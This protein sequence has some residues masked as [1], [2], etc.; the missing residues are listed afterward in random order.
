MTTDHTN[1]LARLHA[2][3]TQ[4][5]PKS[6][7]LIGEIYAQNA[8]FKDPFNEVRGIAAIEHIFA[9]MFVQVDRPRFEIRQTVL[10][11]GNA[12]LVWDFCFHMRRWNKAEQR[13][14]GSSHI[15][16]DSSGKVAHHRDY[17]DAAE[18]LYEK[19]PVL[20]GLMRG[21]KRAAQK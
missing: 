18:E 9:H 17:W 12:F 20:A 15:T 13:I 16:F 21:L 3:F 8:Y 7:A 1:D 11:G 5:N 19:L 4:L 2:F 10:Q 14:H 6:I